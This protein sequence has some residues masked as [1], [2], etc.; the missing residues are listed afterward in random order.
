MGTK[1]I[2]LSDE[3][4]ARLHGLKREGESFSDV[5]NRLAG[6]QAILD[7][8][9]ILSPGEAAGLRTAALGTSR[10]LRTGLDRAGRELGG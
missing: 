2:N 10:R 5:V 8:V 6:K 1:T 3:A 9:G 4:Y 7:I